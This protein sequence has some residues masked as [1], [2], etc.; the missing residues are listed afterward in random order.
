MT[1]TIRSICHVRSSQPSPPGPQPRPSSPHSGAIE[2]PYQPTQRMNIPMTCR[3]PGAFAPLSRPVPFLLQPN[4]SHPT[5]PKHRVGGG[6]WGI[7]FKKRGLSWQET[8]LV[9]VQKCNPNSPT[10]QNGLLHKSLLENCWPRVLQEE[11]VQ[12]RFGGSHG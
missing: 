3:L 5:T 4:C 6:V 7:A 10:N 11:S 1:A 9:S 8:I 12:F 2:Q